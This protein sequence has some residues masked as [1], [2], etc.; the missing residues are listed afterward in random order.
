MYLINSQLRK[1]GEKKISLKNK[2][3][4][5]TLHM[6]SFP[7]AWNFKHLINSELG[8]NGAK[9]FV[10]SIFRHF[11]YHIA[12]KKNGLSFPSFSETWY[13]EIFD[14]LPA[15]SVI[16]L[17]GKGDVEDDCS[18][19]MAKLVNV[20]DRLCYCI[21]KI[22][23]IRKYTSV[24]NPWITRNVNYWSVIVS[25]SSPKLGNFWVFWTHKSPGN[26]IIDLLLYPQDHWN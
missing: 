14:E 24:L 9:E 12:A 2:R 20:S 11:F 4:F 10:I 18:F 26:L 22:T 13:L 25:S 1:I 6:S 19:H 16:L 8:E 17:D 3:K 7:K 23:E 5:K 15:E 21:L